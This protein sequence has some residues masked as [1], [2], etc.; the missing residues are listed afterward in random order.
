MKDDY[1]LFNN[2]YCLK[3]F[4]KNW[5]DTD[6]CYAIDNTAWAVLR[7]TLNSTES[8]ISELA[9]QTLVVNKTKRTNSICGVDT[10]LETPTNVSETAPPAAGA[11]Q[12][13]RTLQAAR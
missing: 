5:W 6:L 7:L 12:Q 11:D 1:S 3:K 4:G 9:K 2:E 8:N 10:C 13:P